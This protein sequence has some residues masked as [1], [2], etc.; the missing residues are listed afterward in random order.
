MIAELTKKHTASQRTRAFALLQ[1]TFGLGNV[2]GAALG[3]KKKKKK[4][5]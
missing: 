2:V 1:V 3:G 5:G 4:K